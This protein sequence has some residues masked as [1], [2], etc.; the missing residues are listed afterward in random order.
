MLAM[1]KGEETKD[2]FYIAGETMNSIDMRN[3][4]C[5]PILILL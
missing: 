2:E 5:I 4:T 3:E 1:M